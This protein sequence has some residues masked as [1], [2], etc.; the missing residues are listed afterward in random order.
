[1][2]VGGLAVAVRVL[3]MIESRGGVL[4][5]L[6]VV[7]VIVVMGGLAVVMGRGFMLRGRL[8]MMLTGRVLFFLCHAW[9]LLQK[10]IHDVSGPGARPTSATN[11]T[12]AT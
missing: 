9:F 8:V 2:L 6:F 10:E 3:A 11:F 12:D 1:M 5:G 7:A 4:P